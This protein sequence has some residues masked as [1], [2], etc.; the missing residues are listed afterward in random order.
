MYRLLIIP[1]SRIWE[2]PLLDTAVTQHKKTMRTSHNVRKGL[3]RE[4]IGACNCY[5]FGISW[6][7]L[8]LWCATIMLLFTCTHKLTY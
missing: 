4:R 2:L 6:T 1:A 3:L 8:T 5:L 7:A